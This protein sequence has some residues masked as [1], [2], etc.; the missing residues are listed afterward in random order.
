[1]LQT[2]PANP[3]PVNSCSSC[4][5]LFRQCSL[6]ERSKRQPCY[7]ETS[8]PVIG[9]LHGVNEELDAHAPPASSSNKRASSR[10]VRKTQVL[11]D[12]FACNLAHPYP[13]NHDKN[14]LALESGLSRTQVM[15]WFTNARR[16][17][18]LTTQ[19]MVNN[20]TFPSG[21]PMPRSLL[22]SMTP[23]ERWRN[24][25]PESDHIS[26]SVIQHVLDTTVPPQAALALHVA[27]S[28]SADSLCYAPSMQNCSIYSSD[29]SADSSRLSANSDSS[30]RSAQS[31]PESAWS[32]N[33]RRCKPRHFPC[34]HCPRT[35]SK[36]YDWIRHERCLHDAGDV[37]WICA[38][39][40]RP[41][42]PFVIWRL[43]QD[44]SECILC[45]TPSP[46]EEHFHS[47][48]FDACARRLVQHRSFSR[49][50]HL[51]QHLVKFH[52]CRKWEGWKPD[53][54]LLQHTA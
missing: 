35:F 38:L 12:W 3:N 16:R 25:P 11:R 37:S 33:P 31:M 53:L 7:F 22:S 36:K 15:N 49:K 4:V 41:N 17:H 1:M 54:S 40:L 50:D 2:T 24:S 43:G 47:H 10:A 14:M 34:S 26:P 23:M 52:G 30:A 48:E 32:G 51:W 9:Q 27:S 20:A 46:T 19:P 21:S 5:A 18:R 29:G 6:A 8:S 45:G 28:A 13:S 44:H 39:P 42:Q